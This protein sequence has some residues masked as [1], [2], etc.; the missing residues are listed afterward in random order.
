[1]ITTLSLLVRLLL[2][3]TLILNGSV[4]TMATAQMM[5]GHD[6]HMID[7][8][9][10]LDPDND[11]T[12]SSAAHPCHPM[13]G[14]AANIP[15]VTA[16]P[17]LH[18]ASDCCAS[19]DCRDACAQHCAAAITGTVVVQGAVIPRVALMLPLPAGHVSPALP[20]LIRPP[21]G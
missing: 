9:A 12:L 1:V 7:S 5:M 16:T 8:G 15:V 6:W 14:A 11:D 20:H 21:I 13:P 3:V 17:S 10:V 2:S 4:G 19:A 18:H